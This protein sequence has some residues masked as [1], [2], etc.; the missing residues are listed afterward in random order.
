MFWGPKCI[1]DAGCTVCNRQAWLTCSGCRRRACHCPCWCHSLAAL[2]GFVLQLLLCFLPWL[3]PQR[4]FHGQLCRMVLMR[5]KLLKPSCFAAYAT[6]QQCE[7]SPCLPPTL[8]AA[9]A[10]SSTLVSCL[11]LSSHSCTTG[12]RKTK[13]MSLWEQR[14]S[15]TLKRQGSTRK[16]AALPSKG[17]RLEGRQESASGP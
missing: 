3:V 11:L 7:F 8:G 17:T 10:G 15:L 12:M 9:S 13:L 2:P 16:S 6:R 4:V 14:L 1:L 5:C